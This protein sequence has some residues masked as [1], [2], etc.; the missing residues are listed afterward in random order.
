MRWHMR[1]NER[2]SSRSYGLP[3]PRNG[4]LNIQTRNLWRLGSRSCSNSCERSMHKKLQKWRQ[5]ANNTERIV[6]MKA[7][8]PQSMKILRKTENFR[9]KYHLLISQNHLTYSYKQVRSTNSLAHWQQLASLL[10]NRLGGRS[11]SLQVVLHLKT[12]ARLWHTCRSIDLWVNTYSTHKVYRSHT[13]KTKDG[14]TFK[15]FLGKT[16]YNEFLLLPFETFLQSSFCEYHKNKLA[17]TGLT[18]SLK[19]WMI[20][21]YVAFRKASLRARAMFPM[22]NGG[23]IIQRGKI[24]SWE[25]MH[26]KMKK[27]MAM[28]K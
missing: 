25:Q 12:M 9:S 27:A 17:V 22:G 26:L 10:C 21:H 4:L 1:Q 15:K 16:E 24:D 28:R 6:V 20:V 23:W 5:S 19:L 8:W 13:G 3:T 11:A 18:F 14:E 7:Q 2:R